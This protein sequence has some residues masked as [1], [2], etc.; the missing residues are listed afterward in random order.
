MFG[1]HD[2]DQITSSR[3]R[4][5]RCERGILPQLDPQVREVAALTILY[6]K[7]NRRAGLVVD[8]D[9]LERRNANQVKTA[10]R[11]ETSGDGDGLYCLIEG[12]C[13]NDL[14][15]SA[16]VGPDESSDGAG[17]RVGR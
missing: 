17:D 13:T 7:A 8:E 4:F 6:S 14:N 11:Y 15:L 2:G 12:A 10:C 1:P 9:I 3:R 5:P 16:A